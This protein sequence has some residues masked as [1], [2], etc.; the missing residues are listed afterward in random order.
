MSVQIWVRKGVDPQSCLT[1]WW[2]ADLSNLLL[3]RRR[4]TVFARAGT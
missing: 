3:Q 4:L 1:T 2:Y